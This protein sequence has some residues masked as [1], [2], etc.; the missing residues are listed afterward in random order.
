M[1]MS[2]IPK[3]DFLILIYLGPFGPLFTKTYDYTNVYFETGEGESTITQIVA[4]WHLDSGIATAQD[5]AFATE[6]NRIA[7]QGKINFVE[8]QFDQLKVAIIDENG[9]E[10]YRQTINGPFDSPEMEE[11]SFVAKTLV[12]PVVSIFKKAKKVFKEEE[13]QRFYS[14]LVSHP[15]TE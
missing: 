3:Q 15:S 1:I 5:A 4:D 6:E 7:L 14:G 8:R 2:Q 9:C 10:R 11:A 12:N 13:C